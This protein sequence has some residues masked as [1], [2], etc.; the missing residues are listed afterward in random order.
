MADWT[1]IGP[2]TGPE[3]DIVR[4]VRMAGREMG[5][6]GAYPT[7]DA[8]EAQARGA[9]LRIGE[10]AQEVPAPVLPEQGRALPDLVQSSPPDR[11]DGWARVAVAGFLADKGDWDGVLCIAGAD[12]S[13]WA[14]VSAGEV[15]SFQGFL[16]PRLVTALG[17]A[18]AADAQAVADSLSRPERLATHLRSA[19]IAGRPEATTG[20][21]VGAELAAARPYWLGQQVAV[22]GQDAPQAAALMAQG[23]PVQEV[24]PQAMR[25][26]GLA[27][28]ADRLGLA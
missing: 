16:T 7:Q 13:H 6:T 1:A 4:L 19:A 8:A 3:G 5:K 9:V 11:L 22:I 24:S 23:V 12:V 15:V 21:L 20:H 17:G 26:A 27:A 28:L 25:A 14:H 10:G 18:G 2:E